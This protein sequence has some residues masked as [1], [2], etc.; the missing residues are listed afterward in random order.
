MRA[1]YRNSSQPRSENSAPCRQPV[2][3]SVL[4]P[5]NEHFAKA[6]LTRGQVAR[7]LVEL[8]DLGLLEA[9]RDEFNI[10]RYKPTG[11]RVA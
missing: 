10:V 2:Q 6:Q 5:Q 7:T 3:Q 1:A 11:G 4:T 9:S 8:V